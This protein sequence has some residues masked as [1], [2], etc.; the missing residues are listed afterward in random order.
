MSHPAPVEK[1]FHEGLC[2]AAGGDFDRAGA[3]FL[4]CV[5]EEPSRGDIVTE[6]LNNLGRQRAKSQQ[7]GGLADKPAG[8]AIHGSGSANGADIWT[9]GPKRLLENPLHV[10]TL[11][12]LAEACRTAGYDQAEVC[13]WKAAVD[14]A[15][16]DLGVH[17]SAA[18][19]LE[20][21]GRFAEALAS[22]RR[23]ESLSA[24]DESVAERIAQCVIQRGRAAAGLHANTSANSPR[25]SAQGAEASVRLPVYSLPVIE[26]AVGEGP[27]TLS[28]MQQLESAIRDR[29]SIAELYLRLAELYLDKDRDYDAERLLAKGREATDNDPRVVELWEE[30][31]LSRQARRAEL[32]E[33]EIKAND[34]PQ[35]RE[36]AAQAARERAKV[37]LEIYRARVK[38]DP[39]SSAAQYALGRRLMQSEKV[40]EAREHLTKA[41]DDPQ[42]RCPA[43]IELARCHQQMVELPQALH[44]YR[45]ALEGAHRGHLAERKAAQA[46][47]AK[48]A[49]KI[50]MPRLAKRYTTS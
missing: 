48:L 35:T 24:S 17:T 30:I 27:R 23:V 40:R 26:P 18:E 38:R 5:I 11:V 12:A 46:A 7:W 32:A 29:P 28:P 16:E 6:F 2:L 42:W 49:E 14:A 19:A 47:A 50:G 15:P 43:A 10:P 3:A 34:T 41:L 25:W 20:R 8:A 9:A 36:A 13:Y 33:Q 4:E 45:L 21:L 37:E 22:W 1:R 39:Q 31:S 44:F